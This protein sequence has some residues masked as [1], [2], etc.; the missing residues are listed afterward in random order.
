MGATAG[1]TTTRRCRLT[2]R[3]MRRGDNRHFSAAR[4][5]A[6]HPGHVRLVV[7]QT[8]GQGRP[9]AVAPDDFSGPELTVVVPT[10]NERD[11]VA[12][13]V[14]RLDGVL[15]GI[16][17]EVVFVDDDSSDGTAEV[18]RAI[19]QKDRRVRVIRRIGRRGLSSAS[20][21]GVP[22]PTYTERTGWEAPS[23]SRDCRPSSRA[24]ASKYGRCRSR[25][26]P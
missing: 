23:N 10:F 21:E 7:M 2:L 1:C 3:F 24:S 16:H 8:V 26:S 18:V 13:L 15:A 19:A 11:N 25:R 12:L 5:A 20:V 22:P 9:L 6:Y 4:L 17:W 14:E